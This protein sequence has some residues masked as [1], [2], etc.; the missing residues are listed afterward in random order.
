[1][2]TITPI[3]RIPDRPDAGPAGIELAI[4][5]TEASGTV[6][7]DERPWGTSIDLDLSGLAPRDSYQLWAIDTAG[8]W[9]T[10]ATW[11]ST[12]QGLA[13]LTGAAAVATTDIDRLVSTSI[14][15]DDVVLVASS[16]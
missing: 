12:P 6:A 15:R 5:Q 1:M 13:R 10:A 11:R 14:D 3:H 16:T 9:T 2:T 7:I 8:N 4:T